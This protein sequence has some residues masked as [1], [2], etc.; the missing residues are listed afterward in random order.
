MPN[1][2]LSNDHHDLGGGSAGSAGAMGDGSPNGP[3]PTC[4][5]PSAPLTTKRVLVLNMSAGTNDAPL[6]LFDDFEIVKIEHLD[7][8][9][10][11]VVIDEHLLVAVWGGDG[12]CRAV[13]EHLVGTGAQMLPCPGGTFNHFAHAAEL[14]TADD[15]K[16]ALT[17]GE[18]RNVD[19]G[20]ASGKVFLNNANLGWYVDLV[21][22]RERYEKRMPRKM[23]KL[24][25]LVVQSV[26]IHRTFVTIDGMDEPVWMV[27]VGNGEYSLA[28]RELTEREDM[29]DGLLDV[30]VLKLHRRMPKLRAFLTLV[31]G[32]AETF[33]GLD[34]RLVPS[35]SLRLRRPLVPASLDGEV[36][37]LQ[38][39]IELHC[40][41][42]GLRLIVPKPV[43]PNGSEMTSS[44]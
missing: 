35:F 36:M 20:M 30:R 1:H 34:R 32:R 33:E 7:E 10:A 6:D 23:A 9:L 16:R 42:N 22:R 27:W 15:V 8:W 18:I 3:A 17:N 44:G 31:S 39:P 29:S 43:V 14:V 21:E 12:S 40:Q 26:R 37:R 28:P 2:A 25:S 5:T 13:A 19:V 38:N 24:L 41:R 11:S 4:S